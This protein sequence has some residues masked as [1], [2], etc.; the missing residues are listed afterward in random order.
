MSFGIARDETDLLFCKV[1]WYSV[2][3][4][5][6]SRL[7]KEIESIEPNRLLNTATEELLSYFKDKYEINVPALNKDG[8]TVDQREMKIDVSRDRSR[9]IY[10][11]SGPFYIDGT[12]VEVEV[13]FSGDAEVFKVQPTSFSLNPPRAKIKQAALVIS[14]EGTDLDSQ[15]VKAE[16]DHT[17]SQIEINLECL[18]QS[19]NQFN[20][21]IPQIALEQID[22]RKN[23]LLKDR[24]L[25]ANLGFQMK[26][27][28]GVEMTFTAPEIKRKPAPILPKASTAPYKPEP[29]LDIQ[30]YNHI[31][32]TIDQMVKVMEYSP[33]AFAHLGEE[34]LRT[35][36]LVPLNAQY[37]GQ[38]TGETFNYQGKTDI[39]IKSQ[40]R[41]I[42][43]AECKI[44]KGA[45]KHIE[46]LDQLLGYLSWRD[47]KAAVIVFNRNK[48]FSTVLDEISKTTIEH[49]NCKKLLR[50]NSETSWTYLFSHKDDPNR[51]MTV[52]V[53]AFDTPTVITKEESGPNLRSA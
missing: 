32:T 21:S 30:Q 9:A 8:I 34:A 20:Q 27:R 4:N 46:T 35:H 50:Q 48:N 47:T 13:P 5:Q 2:T 11:R 10:D 1:D 3:E 41:N 51:E 25:V 49:S 23:K 12:L 40:G 22:R 14:I 15:K 19:A 26:K 17:L 28:E 6:K 29:A 38:A 44:W 53:M 24:D 37:E 39:M 52:T 7:F 42:F 31:L 18:S 43:I 36:F 16:I 45:K 33:E